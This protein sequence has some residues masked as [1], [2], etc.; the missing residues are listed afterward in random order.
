MTRS[1]VQCIEFPSILLP[2][3]C[4]TGSIVSIQ[5]SRN[6]EEEKAR[7]LA[8]WDLQD[9]ILSSFGVTSPAPPALRLRNVTQ[10][11]VTLEWDRLELATARLLSLTIW[12]NGQRL[13]AIPNPANNT[14]TKVSGLD[15]DQAYSF[16]LIMRT[17]AGTFASQTIKTR[18]LTLADTSGVSVCFGAIS[19]P[20]L[21]EEAKTALE[22]MRARSSTRIQIDTT[23]FVCTHAAD[24]PTAPPANSG[25]PNPALEFQRAAQLSIPIVHPSWVLA[26][27]REKK[28]V[29]ISAHYLDK[30]AL[31]GGPSSQERLSRQGSGGQ[32]PAPQPRRQEPIQLQQPPRG[33]SS[34]VS[35]VD[36]KPDDGQANVP[37][38]IQKDDN[39]QTLQT[40]E[41]VDQTGLSE[42]ASD[43]QGGLANATEQDTPQ[44]QVASAAQEEIEAETIAPDEEVAASSPPS[45]TEAQE[46]SR[47]V[48]PASGQEEHDSSATEAEAQ[49]LSTDGEI[50]KDETDRAAGA[51]QPETPSAEQKTRAS[52][53]SN[54]PKHAKEESEG[55]GSLNG[56]M[57]DVKL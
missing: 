52:I 23:H 10:T 53:D 57:E 46:G 32:V 36:A 51:N 35:S 30:A 21:L 48:E 4:T 38:A 8:F 25:Q 9:D 20:T 22:T 50:L 45:T 3:G 12:R 15:V 6:A 43:A 31:S 44:G 27:A 2:P 54:D 49:M 24:G 17:T 40:E 56:S 39:N 7:S 29:P 37:A 42:A 1:Q 26:C 18:T 16:H 47:E 11:S 13:A 55:I 34:T 5:C 28:M 19:P 14:S 33:R 41:E